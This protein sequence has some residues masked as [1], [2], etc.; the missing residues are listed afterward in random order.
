MKIKELFES[1]LPDDWDKSKFTPQTSF[2]QMVAYA[3]ERAIQIGKGSSR[4]AFEIPYQSRPTILK[5]SINQK[6][7]S[8]NQEEVRLLSDWYV[9]GTGI[10]IPMIDYDEAN[11]NRISWIHTEK[12]E[13]I[14]QKQLER[15]FDGFSMQSIIA[16]FEYQKTGRRGFG[17]RELSDS[18]HENENFQALQDLLMNYDDIQ[19]GDL[20]RKANW[21]LYKGR[22][23]I[24]D[25]GFTTET[26]KLYHR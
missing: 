9:K 5:I 22:P 13:K 11:G 12:A 21:G 23:V 24:I 25:L 7:V 1:P 3:K 17:Y 10:T 2:K 4:V 8:Q 26:M 20:T 16:Y 18:I 15:F 6:G 14:S 19:S